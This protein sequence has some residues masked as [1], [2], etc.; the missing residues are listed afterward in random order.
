MRR[1]VDNLKLAPEQ[2]FNALFRYVAHGGFYPFTVPAEE[3]NLVIEANPDAAIIQTLRGGATRFDYDQDGMHLLLARLLEDP[4]GRALGERLLEGM[5][6]ARDVRGAKGL[7]GRRGEHLAYQRAYGGGP[8][9]IRTVRFSPFRRGHGPTF[10]LTL[11]DTHRRDSRG[12]TVLAYKFMRREAGKTEVLFEG[13]D[14]AGSPLHAD[15]SNETIA[16]LMGFL[17]LKPGDTD[18]EY[19][20]NYTPRQLEWAES[21]EP[22]DLD[23]ELRR[24]RVE[25]GFLGD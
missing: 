2:K 20:A 18:A 4:E 19:F 12:Q 3:F 7:G 22:D 16:S 24:L 11:Y 6:R 10:T 25:E 17:T 1:T 15:D 9:L 8:E 13:A 21:G 5:N 14:F 23:Y